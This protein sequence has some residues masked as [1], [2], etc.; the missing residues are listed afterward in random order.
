MANRNNEA[1]KAY[2]KNYAEA[3][4]KLEAIQQH[5]L[6]NGKDCTTVDWGDVGDM[7]RVNELL[8]GITE[9]LGCRKKEA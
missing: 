7:A 1:T 8:A 6:D 2:I 4:D 5:L 9:F 3:S